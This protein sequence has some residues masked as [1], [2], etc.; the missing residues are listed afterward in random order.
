MVVV[1]LL[2]LC[3]CFCIP[4]IRSVC[5][6]LITTAVEDKFSSYQMPLLESESQASQESQ[7]KKHVNS[8]IGKIWNLKK[9]TH[10][11]DDLC[12]DEILFDI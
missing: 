10:H 8:T 4:Y 3:G 12:L 7:E 5:V 1:T 11:F 9:S 6:R 2:V